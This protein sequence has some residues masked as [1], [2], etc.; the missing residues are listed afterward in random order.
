MVCTC[1]KWLEKNQK[2]IKLHDTQKLN[3]HEILVCIDE[4]LFEHNHTCYLV[5]YL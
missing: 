1:F 4:V 5:H 2:E 3:E